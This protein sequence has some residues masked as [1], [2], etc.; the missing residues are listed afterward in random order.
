MTFEIETATKARLADVIVLSQKN[1]LPDE[2]PGAKLSFEIDL[3]N[4]YLSYFDGALLG[5]LFCKN[6]STS[7]SNKP[8]QGELAGVEP[9]SDL[10]DLTGIGAKVGVLNWEAEFTGYRLTV[11]QGLGG[12]KSNLEVDEGTISNLRMKP[13]NGGTFQLKCDFESPNV[14]EATFG[15][16]AKLKSREIDIT[17]TAPLVAQRS[18]DDSG[19]WPFPTPPTGGDPEPVKDAA[20]KGRKAKDATDAFVAA[21]TGG[22]A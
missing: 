21:H 12:P 22:A 19:D 20:S 1:R 15:R 8:K 4:R 5:T 3:P 10:P 9:V 6:A 13:K 18:V 16:L 11:D 14:S 7:A 17:L 2:N